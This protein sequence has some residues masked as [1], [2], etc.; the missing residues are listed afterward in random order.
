MLQS[1]LLTRFYLGNQVVTWLTKYLDLVEL[2]TSTWINSK[3]TYQHQVIE[4]EG[5][6]QAV[7][8]V[9]QRLKSEKQVVEDSTKLGVERIRS[10]MAA[11]RNWT[12]TSIDDCS[13]ELWMQW[14]QQAAELQT[15]R[16]RCWKPEEGRWQLLQDGQ[17]ENC[18]HMGRIVMQFFLLSRIPSLSSP[19][20]GGQ[21]GWQSTRY[22]IA[23]SE[24]WVRA[25][26]EGSRGTSNDNHHQWW[27]AVGK[28][29]HEG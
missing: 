24:V 17:R 18:H 22:T 8:A 26:D 4:Y 28:R 10:M 11:W 12:R 19:E 6:A 5:Q 23:V 2:D 9:I 14:S 7:A 25:S 20:I 29:F 13:A 16:G 27:R 21:V 1:T 15:L 3:T